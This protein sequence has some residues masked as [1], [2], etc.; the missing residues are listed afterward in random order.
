MLWVSTALQAVGPQ[1]LLSFV[2][3]TFWAQRD[4]S[5]SPSANSWELL[6]GDGSFLTLQLLPHAERS[7]RTARC[8]LHTAGRLSDQEEGGSQALGKTAS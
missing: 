7:R 8:F 4:E 3:Q 6:R 1:F 5:R 2:A